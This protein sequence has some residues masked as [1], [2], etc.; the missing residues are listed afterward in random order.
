M[1]INVILFIA[2]IVSLHTSFSY[3]DK[4]HPVKPE[5]TDRDLGKISIIK[6]GNNPERQTKLFF[7]NCF[8]PRIGNL[9]GCNGYVYEILENNFL[10]KEGVIFKNSSSYREVLLPTGRYYVKIYNHQSGRTY[11]ASGESSVSPF[12]TNYVNVELE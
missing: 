4:R 6:T 8:H 9:T 5:R 12:V 11:Y 3:A 10:S 2:I 1:K 7:E